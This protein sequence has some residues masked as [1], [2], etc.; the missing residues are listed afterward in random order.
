MLDWIFGGIDLCL[1]Q[2]RLV[3]LP[4]EFDLRTGK[5]GTVACP[6]GGEAFVT[7]NFPS[8]SEDL[9]PPPQHCL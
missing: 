2:A 8:Q 3:H 6:D 5:R 1:A 7:S 4:G 9:G